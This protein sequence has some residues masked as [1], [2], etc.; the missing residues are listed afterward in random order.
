ML[1]KITSLPAYLLGFLIVYIVFETIISFTIYAYTTINAPAFYSVWIF[2]DSQQTIHFNQIRGYWLTEKPSRHARITNGEIEYI[3][4]YVG[5]AQGFPDRHDFSRKKSNN[6]SKRFIVFGD[7]FNSAQFIET[8]WPDRLESEWSKS[9]N[10]SPSDFPRL[11]LYNFS[12]DG[13]GLANW[14]KNFLEIVDGEN[15]E[16][17]QVI[18][19]ITFHDLRRTFFMADHQGRSH[20]SFGRLPTWNLDSYPKTRGEAEPYMKPHDRTLILSHSRF[21]DALNNK[22]VIN[23]E[24]MK[25]LWYQN[26]W[27]SYRVYTLTKELFNSFFQAQ[28]VSEFYNRIRPPKLLMGFGLSS[29]LD[30]YY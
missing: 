14:H 26:L 1:E 28:Q 23:Y 11:E 17:D 25:K 15:Y 24:A 29:T 22:R 12:T 20:H 9:S 18:F 6:V 3:G 19:A 8:S 5:N 7:S 13:G 2:E 10:R 30:N 27:M 16:Y 21:N 4:T